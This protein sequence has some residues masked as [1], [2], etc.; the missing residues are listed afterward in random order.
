MKR[1]TTLMTTALLALTLSQNSGASVVWGDPSATSLHLPFEY[2]DPSLTQRPDIREIL[3][4]IQTQVASSPSR[5]LTR[6]ELPEARLTFFSE[7]AEVLGQATT[8]AEGR[9]TLARP[10]PTRACQQ[11]QNAQSLA[12]LAAPT[13]GDIQEAIAL[14]KDSCLSVAEPE[15]MIHEDHKPGEVRPSKLLTIEGMIKTIGDPLARLPLPA[16]I[17]TPEL[18]TEM[19]V[20]L[21]K[22]R[23]D[24]LLDRLDRQI[25]RYSKA[26]RAVKSRS[27]CAR[28]AGTL[29]SGLQAL[30][31]ELS[32]L[33]SS[34]TALDRQGRDQAERDR[35]AAEAATGRVR[36][37]LPFPSLTDRER[38]L[39]SL[40]VGGVFWRARGGGLL[41][42]PKGTQMTRID[43]TLLPMRMI[44]YINGGE[45]GARVGESV[46]YDL[47]EPWSEWQDMGRMTGDKFIDLAGMTARG[48]RQTSTA[49]TMLI[50]FGYDPSDLLIGGMQM[51][52]C[53]FYTFEKLAHYQIGPERVYPYAEFL[54]GPTAWGEA[55][56]GAV[57]SLGMSKSLLKGYDRY[58]RLDRGDH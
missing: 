5:S 7:V 12:L 23:K 29:S 15:R 36:N 38:Q 3:P 46:F 49:R 40:Y 47:F 56:S 19:R 13:C 41:E 32:S 18:Q 1:K 37:Q 33:R 6:I 31:G 17:V 16:S 50:Q 28:D 54:E 27:G 57:I 48:Q 8:A 2:T 30:T 11:A 55:C 10:Q 39:L 34:I 14:A 9:S 26:L 35:K 20:I 53:Y 44:G 24:E 4:S 58:G 52:S 42:E 21:T 25:A 51:G 45:D 43:F 22:I